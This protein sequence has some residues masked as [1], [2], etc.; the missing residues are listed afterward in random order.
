MSID[1]QL[2]F[3]LV[4]LIATPLVIL[5]LDLLTPRQD[6]KWQPNV[7]ILELGMLCFS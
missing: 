1:C 2:D 3:F 5:D 7:V 4:F 6:L